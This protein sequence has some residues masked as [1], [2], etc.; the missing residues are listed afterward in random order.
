MGPEKK[1][2]GPAMIVKNEKNR[3]VAF[4]I[5]FLAV[6]AFVIG[7]KAITLAE[8][9]TTSALFMGLPTLV[10]FLIVS[11]TRTSSAYGM[12]VKASLVI[13][14]LVAPLLGEGSICILM[15]AP[16]FL[17]MNLAM[18]FLYKT[19]KKTTKRIFASLVMI[20][21]PFFMGL[22]E[23]NSLEGEGE[24]LK[25]ST[26]KVVQGRAEDWLDKI[27]HSSNISDDIPF[28]LVLGFPLPVKIATDEGQLLVHFDKGGSWKVEKTR[29]D[30]LV[31][32]TLVEDSSKIGSW[33]TIRESLV[34]VGPM[35]ADKTLIRQTTSYRSKVFPE[36]YFHPFQRL[37]LRQ[38]HQLAVSSWGE[39]L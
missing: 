16:L 13:L 14:C 38:L 15:M 35:G 24:F 9:K 25:V 39:G 5:L 7:Y 19:I 6:A 37:A 33:I 3:R 28:F 30:G 32:Y 10:G 4:S 12:T 8:L 21:L 31:K 29:K 17:G 20:A 36:W 26:E 27:D 11:L 34:E 18:V 22:V 23:K 1:G 2:E